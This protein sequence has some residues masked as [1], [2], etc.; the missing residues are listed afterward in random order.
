M[1]VTP[2]QLIMSETD[3]D[4]SSS[5]SSTPPS[6]PLGFGQPK[7]PTFEEYILSVRAKVCK[8]Q[9]NIWIDVRWL[10][11]ERYVIDKL[12]YVRFTEK[13]KTPYMYQGYHAK[14]IFEAKEGQIWGT[15]GRRPRLW[16][17]G[18]AEAGTMSGEH[19]TLITC[20]DVPNLPLEVFNPYKF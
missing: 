4:G 9:D 2:A 20:E 6:Q 18:F 3:S 5:S 8:N 1:N 17:I 13:T 16:R 15:R 11:P 7:Y 12:Y 14:Y 19:Q 10:D